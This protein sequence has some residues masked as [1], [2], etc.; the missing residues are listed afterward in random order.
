MT[1]IDETNNA[2]PKFIFRKERDFGEII[3]DSFS[4]FSFIYNNVLHLLFESVGLFVL[5]IVFGHV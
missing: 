5:L 4:C 3:T 2:S 1:P